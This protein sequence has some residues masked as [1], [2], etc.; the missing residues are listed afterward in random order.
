MMSRGPGIWLVM[1]AL[2]AC[3]A[4]NDDETG[5][6]GTHLDKDGDT[7]PALVFDIEQEF[8]RADP[9]AESPSGHTVLDHCTTDG[10]TWPDAVATISVAQTETT[11]QVDI[12]VTDA[13]PDT[14]FSGWLRLKGTDPDTGETWGGNP[15]TGKGSTALAPSTDLAALI[16]MSEIEGATEAPNALWT[17]ADGNGTLSVTLDLPMIDGAYPFDNHDP[18]LEPVDTVRAPYAPFL[19]RLASHCTDDLVHGILQGDREMWFNWSP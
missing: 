14:L 10:E 7:G 8:V 11:T 16:A 18:S 12:T 3:T 2:C 19:V 6:T 5:D 4:K 17:D 13:R 9:A 1:G 15:I